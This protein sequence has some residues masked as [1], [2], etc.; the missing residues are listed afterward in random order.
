MNCMSVIVELMACHFRPFHRTASLRAFIGPP[1]LACQVCFISSSC[2]ASKGSSDWIAPPGSQL[3]P[4]IAALY[5]E[6][7]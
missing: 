6:A 1:W 5:V 7:L 2:S 3:L 4:N